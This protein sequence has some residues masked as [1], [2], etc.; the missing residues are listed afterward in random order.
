MKRTHLLLCCTMLVVAACLGSCGNEPTLPPRDNPLDTHNPQT[1]GDPYALHCTV[2][3]NS[4]LLD[5]GAVDV[6]SLFKYAILRRHGMVGTFE[7]IGETDPSSRQYRD[8]QVS[9]GCTYSYRVVVQDRGGAQS[10]ELPLRAITVHT[11]AGFSVNGSAPIVY[12]RSVH[13]NVSAEDCDSLWAWNG[14]LADSASGRWLVKSTATAEMEW[15][16][17]DDNGPQCVR[18]RLRYHTGEVRMCS[19]QVAL[20]Y[21]VNYEPTTRILHGERDPYNATEW[22]VYPY[23]KVYHEDG[24]VSAHSFT[25]GD[26]IP[27]P[28][29]VVCKAIGND[30]ARDVHVNAQQAEVRF[31][32]SLCRSG[33]TA[34]P[35]S[36]AHRTV[37][38]ER[39]AL[40]G[41]GAADTIGCRVGPY[42]YVLK[43]RTVDE[44]GL[45]DSTPDS[46]I[47]IGQAGRPGIQKSRIRL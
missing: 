32:G 25:W 21:I 38:W 2:S 39:S 36:V 5:W 43:V 29:Y 37:S 12:Q 46:V 47:F 6:S 26:S 3:D 34:E 18:A 4:V 30:D 13:I 22:I 40:L 10:S 27:S 9:A 19:A 15:L 8:S 17:P 33:L 16:L 42:S 23:F 1:V 44:W 45:A 28:S 7:T 35:F 11:P 20:N 31:Q 14:S 41:G 24:T